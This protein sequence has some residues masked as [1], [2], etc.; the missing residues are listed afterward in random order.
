MA[1]GDRH[2]VNWSN[3]IIPRLYAAGEV[4]SVFLNVTQGGGNITE[5]VVSGRIAGANAAAEAAW[6]AE[7]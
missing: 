7:N 2:V 6:D 5:C 1:D 4:A 3:E